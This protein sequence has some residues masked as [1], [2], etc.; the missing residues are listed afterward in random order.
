MDEL[1]G[2]KMDMQTCRICEKEFDFDVGGLGIVRKGE[3]LVVCGPNCAKKAALQ[4]RDEYNASTS[5]RT[6]KVMPRKFLDQYP[7]N[8]RRMGPGRNN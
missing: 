5:C 6:P 2:T 7:H 3:D 8:Q 4:A 1:E